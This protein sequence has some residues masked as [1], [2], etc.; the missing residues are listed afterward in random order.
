MKRVLTIVL[1]IFIMTTTSSL[2]F[3]KVRGYQS[4]R[5]SIRNN[6][7]YLKRGIKSIAPKITTNTAIA[8]DPQIVEQAKNVKTAYDSDNTITK[9]MITKRINTSKLI[10]QIR[11][12]RL[13]LSN[14]QYTNLNSI[15]TTINTEA[16]KIVNIN[17]LNN[18]IMIASGKNTTKL[19]QVT[20]LDLT[21]MLNNINANIT[22]LNT[23]SVNF[24]TLNSTLTGIVNTIPAVITTPAAITTQS[25]INN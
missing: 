1:A 5:N 2:A 10:M 24:D 14:D 9:Q 22:H 7:A 23:I 21:T 12:K 19:G 8:L 4:K 3:A 15:I 6:A 11:R 25:A 20:L 18:A 16:T 17:G 13:T